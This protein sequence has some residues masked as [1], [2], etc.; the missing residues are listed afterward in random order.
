MDFTRRL[1]LMPLRPG[2]SPGGFPGIAGLLRHQEKAHL[3][4]GT[5]VTEVTAKL[6]SFLSSK[7]APWDEF[8]S[9][10]DV[11]W[12]KSRQLTQPDS[13]GVSYTPGSVRVVANW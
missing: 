9:V 1:V 7:L 5:E 2:Q 13:P 11:F 12:C 10:F 6:R 8:W 4:P 3:V